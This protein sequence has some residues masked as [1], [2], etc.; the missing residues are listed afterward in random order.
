MTKPRISASKKEVKKFGYLFAVI[1]LGVAAYSLYRGGHT[2]PWFIGGSVFFLATGL[3][4]YPVLRPIYVGWMTF[5]FAL[6]WVNTRIILGLFFYVILTPIGLL[7]RAFGKDLLEERIDRSGG[8]Y[9]VKRE[10][11]P[12]E[13]SRYERPF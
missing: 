9:W 12:F 1:C 8:T 10:Q 4:V 2:W 6:G 11:K 3:F 13:A 5:A 7:M